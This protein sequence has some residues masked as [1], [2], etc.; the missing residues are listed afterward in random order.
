M[1]SAFSLSLIDHALPM[2]T[3]Q[4]VSSVVCF[5]FA[6]LLVLVL[7]FFF[8]VFA[9]HFTACYSL[10]LSMRTKFFFSCFLIH[11]GVSGSNNIILNYVRKENVKDM[12]QNKII[13]LCDDT[14]LIAKLI[15]RIVSNVVQL[16]LIVLLLNRKRAKR[17]RESNNVD[18]ITFLSLV[19]YNFSQ[20]RS[21]IKHIRWT[22][23]TLRPY[24][25]TLKYLF[26]FY[27]FFCH[28]YFLKH[29]HVDHW[30]IVIF[31]SIPL[32]KKSYNQNVNAFNSFHRDL[33]ACFV[34]VNVNI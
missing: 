1:F 27:F 3:S 12:L 31:F 5:S 32:Y 21:T 22:L 4:E 25:L 9:S 11:D 28:F 16:D 19:S 13:K 8:S 20:L 7:I 6:F 14:L 33:I 23:L 2:M 29:A 24:Y 15:L 18:W 26:Y 30:Q 10:D 17:K 34:C